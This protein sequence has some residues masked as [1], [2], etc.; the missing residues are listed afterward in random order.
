MIPDFDLS[1]V[2]LRGPLAPIA[3]M[4]SDGDGVLVRHADG[5]WLGRI[6]MPDRP[7][8]TEAGWAWVDAGGC[9][10]HVPISRLD[11]VDLVA[12]PAARGAVVAWLAS[13]GH[14][15]AGKDDAALLSALRHVCGLPPA[16]A[17][18][19]CDTEDIPF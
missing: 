4:L 16:P 14:A 17:S 18:E 5:G 12:S 2:P 7:R 15:D 1:A 13:Q 19:S 9:W 6:G 10:L 11:S 3:G 8:Y